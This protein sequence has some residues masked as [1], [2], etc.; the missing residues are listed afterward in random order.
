[1]PTMRSRLNT[2]RDG[3]SDERGSSMIEFAVVATLLFMLVFGIVEFGLAFRDRLT[4][5][6]ASQSAARVGLVR[7]RSGS[8]HESSLGIDPKKYKAAS[9]QICG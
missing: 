7:P 8:F 1:M 6:N 5:G 4:V 3:R 9:Q 2:M